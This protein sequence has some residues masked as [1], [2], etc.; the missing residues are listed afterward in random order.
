MTIFTSLAALLLVPLGA[1]QATEVTNLRCEYLVNP[2]GIDVGKPRLSWKL[3]TGNLKPERG[4]KQT[5]YQILVASSEVL[6]KKDQADLWDSGKVVSEQSVLVEYHGKPQGSWRQCHWKVRSWDN[7]GKASGWSQPAAWTMGLLK[8]EDWQAKWIG[9]AT[10]EHASL[11]LRRDFA[12]KSG[13]RRAIVA[14]CGLGHYE[15]ALNGRKVTEDVLTPGWT[16]YN[17]TCLYDMVD[18]TRSLQPG[19]NAVGLFLGNGMYNVKGGRYAKFTGSFGP[20]KAIAQLRLEFEDGT[21][22]TLVT[23]DQW[24][25][26]SGPVTFNCV[27]GGEDY[28]AR[29]CQSGWDQPG[30][31]D[32]KWEPAVVTQGPGGALK[33]LACAAPPVRAFDTFKPVKITAIRP[34]VTLYDLGQNAAQMPRITVSGPRGAAVKLSPAEIVRPDNSIDQTSVGGNISCSYWLDGSGKET[35]SPRFFYC[36]YRYLQV[37]CIAASQGGALPVVEALES[38]VVHTS[39]TPIGEFS[40]SNELIN[41]IYTMIRWAQRS[42][43]VSVMTDCPHREKLGWL[44]QTHLNGPALRYNYDLNVFFNK[45]MNDMA[46]SQLDDGMVP[47]IAPEYPVFGGGFRDSP[48]WG[49][50][51]PQVAWH[52]YQTAGDIELLRRYYDG[53]ARYVAYLEKKA[54]GGR[55]LS[56]GLGDWRQLESTPNAVTATTIFYDDARILEKIAELLGKAGDAARYSKLAAEIRDAFNK[57]FFN[58][59]TKQYAAG[60]QTANA[61]PLDMG[62]VPEENRAEVLGSLVKRLQADG[63]KAGEI[64]FPYLLRA[65]AKGGRSDVIFAMINQTDKPGYGFQLNYGATSLPEDWDYQPGNSQ[66]H[67]MLGHINEWFYHDLAG[68]QRDPAAVGF[69]KIIIKPVPVGDLTWV[70]A[71]YDSLYGRIVS[72]WK[73]EGAPSTDSTSTRQAG[74]RAGKLTMD[75]TIPVN[76]T[77]TVYVPA[78]DATGV[79]ESGKPAAKAE[80]VIFLRMENSAAVYAVGSGAYRFQSALSETVKQTQK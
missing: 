5:A 1:L 58:A 75:I 68:I 56:D 21:S 67:F 39:S 77:A 8:P 42:N 64:G 54:G 34:G 74:L 38:R 26:S 12:V 45:L 40:T 13:L 37:E 48:E 72:N 30:F 44:E 17:K 15:L 80:G 59:A 28:D 25:V 55:I 19:N 50:A 49:S 16:K 62:M 36:G 11:L 73:R 3:E 71:H 32:A 53:M 46:D 24:R 63:L 29:L 69:K 66:N 22:E 2:L 41:R 61:I 33:G 31:S 79:T 35:W 51:F 18:V 27:Y 47:N 57:Q 65:L 60:T 76:T 78:K 7:G 4:I 52:Q 20:Q 43:M 9:A 6:L 10:Q 23:D 70:K 14:V